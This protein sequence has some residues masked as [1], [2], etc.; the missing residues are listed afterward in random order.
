M[1]R[2]RTTPN[3]KKLSTTVIAVIIWLIG[4]IFNYGFIEPSIDS[5]SEMESIMTINLIIGILLTVGLVGFLCWKL[6]YWHKEDIE[7]KHLEEKLK[8]EDLIDTLIKA[9]EAQVTLSTQLMSHHVQDLK[10][11]LS[12]VKVILRDNEIHIPAIETLLNHKF[13]H[14]VSFKN[15]NKKN[16]DEE[17]DRL[18][19]HKTD[20]IL[21]EINYEN[22][23]KKLNEVSIK[24]DW[25]TVDLNNR[26]GE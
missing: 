11:F 5:L 8:R 6:W 15:I 16:V 24:E 4:Q 13:D 12:A 3:K 14:Y 19:L 21:H 25:Q 26:I 10:E 18:R 7:Q 9:H 23:K 20:E 2:D 1:L 22:R 17:I